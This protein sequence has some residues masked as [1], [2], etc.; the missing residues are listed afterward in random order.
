MKF[1]ELPADPFDPL[2][3][4]KDVNYICTSVPVLPVDPSLKENPDGW[5]EC[6]LDKPN[7]K[8]R[9][10]STCLDFP[11]PIPRLLPRRYRVKSSAISSLGMFATVDIK[12]N[13]LIVA[14]RPLLIA[15]VGLPGSA[16]ALDDHTLTD[17]QKVLACLSHQEQ[18]LG[19]SLERMLPEAQAAYKSLAN[20]HLEDGSGPLL[21]VMRTNGF[22]V[23]FHGMG[24]RY[25][26]I[27]NDLSRVNHRYMRSSTHET[28]LI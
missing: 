10:F 1:T 5:C 22:G 3:S 11:R 23:Q 13:D 28:D 25:T 15:P 18:F 9:I 14:E 24:A 6:I 26:A 7:L 8:K 20:S 21:G 19:F 16:D 4:P 17:D 12:T 27:Y 2:G